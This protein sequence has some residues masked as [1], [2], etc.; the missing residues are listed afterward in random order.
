MFSKKK[1]S[2]PAGATLQKA[3]VPSPV[4]IIVLII[5][6]CAIATYLV[7]A[8]EFAR[9]EDPN[10]G[11]NVVDPDSFAYVD[12]NP[13]G[14]MDLFMSITKGIQGA[15]SIIGFLFII[16]GAFAMVEATGAINNGLG[17]V[18]RKMRGRELLLIPVTMLIFSVVTTLAACS[19][20]YI[21]FLPLVLSVC[22]A[23]GFDSLTAL[24]IVFGSIATGYCSACTNAFTVGIAQG[25]AGLPMF[26]GIELRIAIL[27][28]MYIIT[29]A[30]VMR[31]AMKVKKNPESSPM[32][33]LDKNRAKSEDFDDE[34]KLTKRQGLVLVVFA[35][36]MVYLVYGV[37]KHGYYIDELSAIFLMMGVLAG[38]VGGLKP[39]AMADAFLQGCRNMLVPCIMVGL[40]KASTIILTDAAVLDTIINFLAGLL[41]SLPKFLTAFGMF[42][43]Q[44]LFNVL[45]PSG[46]GQAAI[47]MPIM[48]PLADVVG[49]TRQTA[50]LAFQFGDAITNCITPASGMTISCLTIAGVPLKKWWKFVLPLVALWW[51]VAFGFLTYAT[52]IGYGPF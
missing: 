8:G 18:V 40:C 14:L 22:F 2:A 46:S 42:V 24:G 5:L 13:V 35:A 31:H 36:A 27:V 4:T 37:I 47:T 34:Q 7:P 43:V 49:V 29:T 28:V 33:E 39:R 10:T 12:Q 3:N 52:M 44:D 38:I 15:S 6:I 1:Q 21:A 23:M 32:Y 30:F 50:V 16:G 17:V 20:E 41:G 19:E 48:A 51:I 25:I 26:S 45:V 9:V 11:R